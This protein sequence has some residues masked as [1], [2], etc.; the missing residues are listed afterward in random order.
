MLRVST[1]E[2]VYPTTP[3]KVFHKSGKLHVLPSEPWRFYFGRLFSRLLACRDPSLPVPCTQLSPVRLTPPPPPP[4]RPLQIDGG[5]EAQERREGWREGDSVAEA[6][7]NGNSSSGK[8]NNSSSSIQGNNN[9]KATAEEGIR[10]KGPSV[11]IEGGKGFFFA[12]SPETGEGGGAHRPGRSAGESKLEGSPTRVHLRRT[13]IVRAVVLCDAT[14]RWR[15][16][17]MCFA[18]LYYHTVVLVQRYDRSAF[19]TMRV[20]LDDVQIKQSTAGSKYAAVVCS[21][22]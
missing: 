22:L 8:D 6:R 12:S 2:C 16:H 9:S 13:G 3:P 17:A 1:V 4:V 21:R 20:F 18:Y 5:T 11:S 10:G 14:T 19:N 7:R 15:C